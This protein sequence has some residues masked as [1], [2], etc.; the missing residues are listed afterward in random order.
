MGAYLEGDN[1]VTY[2][3]YH[4]SEYVGGPRRV[5]QGE[6]IAKLGMTGNAGAPHTHFEMRPGGRTATAINP[7]PTLIKICV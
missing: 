7:Y 4:L 3:Y 6:V 2:V 1:G 5:A